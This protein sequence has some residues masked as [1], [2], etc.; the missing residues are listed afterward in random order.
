MLVPRSNVRS[1]PNRNN[2]MD[3]AHLAFGLAYQGSFFREVFG[4]DA[5]CLITLRHPIAACISTYEKSGGLP[6]DGKFC[7]RSKIE[8]WAKTSIEAMDT[9]PRDGDDYFSAYL[10]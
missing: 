5:D 7:V 4:P 8:D 2:G 6:A 10:H 1:L 3:P 9:R